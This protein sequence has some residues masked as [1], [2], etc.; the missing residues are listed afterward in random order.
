[1]TQETPKAMNS[2]NMGDEGAPAII[3]KSI[4]GR[5]KKT[6]RFLLS[7]L[8]RGS[9]RYKY[10]RESILEYALHK[11]EGGNAHN[12]LL[13][14]PERNFEGKQTNAHTDRIALFVTYHPNTTTPI[15]NLDYVAA[16]AACGF[17]VIYIHNGPLQREHVEKLT[18]NCEKIICRKNIGQDFGAWKDGYLYLK[19]Q[20]L[21]N[22]LEWLLLCNDS[23]LFLGGEQGTEFQKRLQH[24]LDNSG[25]TDLICLNLN[26]QE[27]MHYQSYFLCFR[28]P[29]FKSSKFDLFW[30]KYL[31]ISHRYHAINNGEI[32]LTRDIILGHR[33]TVLYDSTGLQQALALQKYNA[34]EIYSLLPLGAFYLST[35]KSPNKPINPVELQRMFALLDC[36]NP[37]HVYALL[38]VKLLK[39]PFLKKDLFRHGIFGQTQLS[40]LLEAAGIEYGSEKW[41]DFVNMLRS[42]GSNISYVRYPDDAFRKGIGTDGLGALKGYGNHLAGLG[43]SPAQAPKTQ[44]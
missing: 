21:L 10:Y 17:R 14:Y 3:K 41:L 44:E 35:G 24:K 7:K 6:I 43:L 13:A 34:S 11:L 38:F 28:S 19:R 30:R 4:G 40:L 2:Q 22:G 31:P 37:S 16:L 32:K 18:S 36:Y 15:S 25:D 33:A 26:F 9:L 27:W 39:S 42:T 1:M 5:M 23:N 8:A 29:L 20:G 12:R